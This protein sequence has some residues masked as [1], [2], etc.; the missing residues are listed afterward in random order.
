MLSGHKGPPPKTSTAA[1][2][3][4]ALGEISTQRD[5][6]VQHLGTPPVGGAVEDAYD[7]RDRAAAAAAV[8]PTAASAAWATTEEAV[9]STGLLLVSRPV[10]WDLLTKSGVEDSRFHPGLAGSSF[11]V[12]KP[13]WTTELTSSASQQ[14]FEF[15]GLLLELLGAEFGQLPQVLELPADCRPP[16]GGRGLKHQEAATALRPVRIIDA[17]QKAPVRLVANE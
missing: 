12:E 15:F 17:R 8:T 2:L 3:V 6:A 11:A 7:D 1:D 4:A 10:S 14:S 9:S 16:R 5:A 13:N